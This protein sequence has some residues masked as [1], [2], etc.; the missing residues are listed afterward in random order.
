MH[1]DELIVLHQMLYEIKQDLEQNNQ[2]SCSQYNALKINPTQQHRSKLEHK[3]A[4]FVLGTEIAG[5]L[6][7]VESASSI[8]ISARMRDLADRTLKEMEYAQ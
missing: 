6:Q 8:R 1:K 2:I 5:M 3:H 4:I 7:D